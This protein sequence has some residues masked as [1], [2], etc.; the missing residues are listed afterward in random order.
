MPQNKSREFLKQ[1]AEAVNIG[2]VCPNTIPNIVCDIALAP[3]S[4][5]TVAA[6]LWVF[7]ITTKTILPKCILSG[8]V[9]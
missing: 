3:V 8:F 4:N 1:Y 2:L 5:P 7:K 6:E 9:D